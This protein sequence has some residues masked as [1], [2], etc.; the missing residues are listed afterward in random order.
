VKSGKFANG[1]SCASFGRG[2]QIKEGRFD[3]CVFVPYYKN[4]Q[5]KDFLI[6][7]RSDLVQ[8]AEKPHPNFARF[9][10]TNP[11]ILIWC[12]SND[13]LKKPLEQVGEQPLK[14]EEMLHKHP[15]SFKD[16]WDKIA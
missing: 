1:F 5:I 3:Y 13:D 10:Y 16:A 12:D 6:F 14:I 9:R 4:Y 2:T 8:V 15:E 11:C 7:K